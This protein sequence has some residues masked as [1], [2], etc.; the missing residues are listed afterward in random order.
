MPEVDGLADPR[1]VVLTFANT[2]PDGGGR[3]ERFVDADGLR[4]WLGQNDWLG[5]APTRAPITDADAAE[6]RE[7]RDALVTVLLVH[8][9]TADITTEQ[10]D[11]AESVLRR[12]AERYPVMAQID[13]GG[14]RLQPARDGVPGTLGAVLAAVGELSLAGDWSRVKACRNEPCHF[15][16]VDKTR[17]TSAAFCSPECASQS[18]MR[19][20]R[21]RRRKGVEK[22]TLEP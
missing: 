19:A 9:R 20:Y 17:N 21:A 22:R 8:S 11:E 4:G 5:A 10:V 18:S 13:R 2:H 6:A 14:A 1:Y 16:F 15:A 3:T 12:A 7:L